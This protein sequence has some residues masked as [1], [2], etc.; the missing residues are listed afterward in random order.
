MMLCRKLF[1][2]FLVLLFSLVSISGVV[3]AEVELDDPNNVSQVSILVNLIP[4]DDYG[5][6]NIFNASDVNQTNNFDVWDNFTDETSIFGKVFDTQML[7][8]AMNLSYPSS[9]AYN[10]DFVVSNVFSLP[11]DYYMQGVQQMWIRLPM[12]YSSSIETVHI[13][14]DCI[15]SFQNIVYNDYSVVNDYVDV[16]GGL[17]VYNQTTYPSTSSNS[18]FIYHDYDL[19][20]KNSSYENKTFEFMYQRI[21]APIYSD[22]YYHISFFVHFKG[23]ILAD[24][25]CSLLFNDNDLGVEDNRWSSLLMINES[26][27]VEEAKE[28]EV[29]SAMGFLGVASINDGMGGWNMEHT[30]PFTHFPH[31]EFLVRL[32]KTLH[33]YDNITFMLPMSN[34]VGY[35]LSIT[36]VSKSISV[37]VNASWGAKRGYIFSSKQYIS[38]STSLDVVLVNVTFTG[39]TSIWLQD[40]NPP[41]TFFSKVDE[42]NSFHYF[43]SDYLVENISLSPFYIMQVSDNGSWVNTEIPPIYVPV[44]SYVNYTW[45][46]E[47]KTSWNKLVVFIGEVGETLIRWG[48][49]TWDY[50]KDVG[51]TVYDSLPPKW[52]KTLERIGDFLSEFARALVYVGNWVGDAISKVGSF[53]YHVALESYDWIIENLPMIQSVLELVLRLAFIFLVFVI[54]DVI[55]SLWR[56]IFKFYNILCCAGGRLAIEFMSTTSPMDSFGGKILLGGI[57]Q[58]RRMSSA[59]ATGGTSEVLGGIT[60]R[61]RRR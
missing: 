45:Y 25:H 49:I 30:L 24:R 27:S 28:V 40:R 41:F 26:S 58:A 35:Q 7:P 29:C 47:E 18:T 60:R 22:L 48:K 59:V 34:D 56:K 9:N 5:V 4:N 53:V 36:D 55:V 11:A 20:R 21:D 23:F 57:S 61:F 46:P 8:S 42:F 2:V 51:H 31:I 37:L 16:N 33:Q 50:A 6:D 14:I 19:L 15:H 43:G 54:F 1:T 17:T 3:R 12:L 13:Q 52:Q 38:S 10:K 32:P 39:N 44:Y